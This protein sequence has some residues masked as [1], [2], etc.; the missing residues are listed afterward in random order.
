MN[1]LEL[2]N[3]RYEISA[4]FD[5]ASDGPVVI[6]AIPDPA[7]ARFDKA[8]RNIIT[9]LGE[10]AVSFEE[11]ISPAKALRWKRLFHAQP[12]TLDGRLQVLA[13]QVIERCSLME[14]ALDEQLLEELSKASE[15]VAGT[16]SGF[17]DELPV[18]IDDVVAWSGFVDRVF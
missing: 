11:L 2:L 4:R 14:G 6:E 18:W 3:R 16:D 7:G 13:E 8:L 15:C 12:V 1:R 9:S 17:A 10:D 5:G